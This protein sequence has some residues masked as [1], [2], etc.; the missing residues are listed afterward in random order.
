MDFMPLEIID[1]Y[2]LPIAGVIGLAIA[3]YKTVDFVQI[4]LLQQIEDSHEKVCGV[5]EGVAV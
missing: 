3:L 5:E 2:G 1:Q 4:K